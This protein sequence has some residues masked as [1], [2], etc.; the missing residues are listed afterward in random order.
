MKLRA[1]LCLVAISSV[2]A[3]L[4]AQELLGLNPQMGTQTQLLGIDLSAGVT[5][6]SFGVS[7]LLETA[8]E[9]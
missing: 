2:T 5:T 3:T 1:I 6:Q 8:S 9:N 7:A 4:P